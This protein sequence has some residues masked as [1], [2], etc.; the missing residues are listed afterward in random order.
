MVHTPSGPRTVAVA[1]PLGTGKSTLFDAMLAAAGT[2]LARSAARGG[3]DLRLAHT[4]FMGEPWTLIDC[5]GSVECAHATEHALAV[6]DL[7]LVVIDP[8]PARAIT[9]APLLHSLGALGLPFLVFINH[10]D[11]M[12]EPVRE[13]IA[14]L[15]PFAP[16]PLVQREIPIRSGGQVT[17]FIDVISERA[18]DY[19]TERAPAPAPA[20]LAAQEAET[21]AG[22]VEIL[23]DH[24]D[25]LL[26]KLIEDQV[27][28]SAEIYARLRQEQADHQV[29]GVLFG[30]ADRG[31]G[32]FRLWKAL[33]HDTPAASDTAARR[34]VAANGAPLAQ[35][36]HTLHTGQG[37]KLS[38]A[39]IWR[40]PV[41][42]GALLHGA[43]IGSMWKNPAG[44]PARIA[45]AE[46]GEIVALGRLEAATT[47]SVLGDAAPSAL[48]VPPP[49]PPVHAVA[50]A[51]RD[52]KDDV[53][54]PGALQKLVD[55]FP[56]LCV[57]HDADTG[58]TLLAGQGEMQLRSALER[59]NN[60]L[61]VPVNSHPPA[62]AYRETIRHNVTQHGR[63][64]RQTGGHG[65]FADV[66]L[67]IAPLPRGTGF[68]FVDRIVGGAVPRN[69]IPAVAAGAEE[70]ARKGAFGHPVVDIEVTLV[71]GGYHDV[72]SSEMAFRS[73][74]RQAMAEAFP[75]AD[76]VLLEPVDQVTVTVPSSYSAAA[77]R[78]LTGRRGQILGY[79]EHPGRP[80]WDDVQALVPQA[81]LYGI[82]IELRSQ[83]MGLATY[84]RR[85]DH[86]A[87]LHGKAAAAVRAAG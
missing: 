55:E 30:A 5:P 80:G 45:E 67:H 43:R 39:R 22:L 75:N 29:A 61:G 24:D 87:E 2:P 85:F 48:V 47:G 11:T 15:R 25:A 56:A 26:E 66:K 84:T 68:R 7:A 19:G 54:M 71:D 23:A 70:A 14:A 41:K 20:A 6:A 62:I 17:G 40:G 46:A 69:F 34:G 44:E 49:P 64:K 83:T 13:I 3:A 4:S 1:G 81:D 82:I 58:E 63:L 9:A 74:T 27:V 50:I 33:R 12:T 36:F 79:D 32:V 38:W 57:V 65:Q 28:S 52:R 37:G 78:V 59:L 8:H 42:D 76:P 72:D 86:L 51:A 18:Y 60:G 35:V 31:W 10:I 53:R 73:A 77:Q 16:C 21:R